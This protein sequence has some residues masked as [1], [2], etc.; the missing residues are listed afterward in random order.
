MAISL[1]VV[2]SVTPV[3]IRVAARYHLY[4]RPAGHKGHTKPTPYLGGAAVMAGFLLTALLLTADWHRTAPLV[5]GVLVM[6]AVGTID[7]KRTV[8]PQLRV[9]TEVALATLF[10]GLG[11]GWD[12]G[13]GAAV[14]WAATAVWVVAVVNA[15]NLFDNM[16][17]AASAM[18]TVV[19]AALAVLGLVQDDTW[20]AVVSIA[21]CG[22]CIG[23]LPHNLA[24]PSRIFLGDGG[25]MPMGFTV[26][27][28]AMVGTSSAAPEWQS[29]AM[30]LLLVGVPAL[31]T[32]LVIV[33]RKRR[34]V[35]V[36]AGGRDHITHR[37]HRRLRTARAVA[38]TLGA[39]QALVS[40][41]ALVAVRGNSTATVLVVVLYLTA[42]GLVIALL[43][44]KELAEPAAGPD[45]AEAAPARPGP[46][47]G[48]PLAVVFLVPLGIAVGLSP[49]FSGYYDATTWVPAALGLV[50]IVAAGAIARP[51]RVGPQAAL[52]LIGLAGL[53]L[54]A[55]ASSLWADSIEQAVVEGNR[56]L[57]YAVL[58]GAL[59][60]TVRDRRAAI[61]LLGTI[62]A[63]AVVVAG[64][65]LVRMLGDDA[66]SLFVA[67][68]LDA[69][70]GYINGQAS[71]Y[72]LT[73]WILIA[74]AERRRAALAGVALGA[75]TAVASLLVLSQSRG[76][77]VAAA[78]SVVLVLALVPG[79]TRRACAL[80]LLAAGVG[81]A[82]PTLVDVYASGP[83][84]I[85]TAAANGAASAALVAGAA[86]GLLWA[87]ATF[88][89]NRAG[90]LEPSLRRLAVA[91]VVAVGVAL[92]GAALVEQASIRTTL[93]E[94]YRAFV[95]LGIEPQGSAT[96]GARPTTRLASGAGTRYDYWRI[97]WQA[98][99]EHPVAGVGAGNY[100]KSY[101]ARRATTEDVRQPHSIEL[102]ALSELGLLGAAL[103]AALLGGI[104]WG[105]WRAAHAARESA[106]ARFVCVAGVGSVAAW[107][108]HTSVDWI[109]LLPG[110]TAIALA[111]A[112]TLLA[113]AWGRA[114]AAEPDAARA[115]GRPRVAPALAVGALIV[116][117][118][119]SL[120]RQGLADHF[121]S[122]AQDALAARPADALTEADRA[123]RL[124]A[125]SVEAYYVKAAALARFGRG[126]T[127]RATLLEAARREPRD[128]VTWTLLGDLAVRMGDLD[129]ARR[130]Y[131][132]ALDL[133]PRDPSLREL[134]RDPQAVRERSPG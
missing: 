72:L 23:F 27:V 126:A 123:L 54:L 18:G 125:E 13:F 66:A 2:Y 9:A 80:L 109:H 6:W 19:T 46:L 105:A 44:S 103:L 89:V 111:A 115:R 78:A 83:G 88:A 124:D 32:A 45:A 122:R 15:F 42:A 14:D 71:F 85:D 59:L 79:R 84:R 70:L 20:V 3:A 38:L 77:A 8:T 104:A 31:D 128:F 63:T 74:V 116:V 1:V 110:V 30:G 132:R 102:Q 73:L 99:R 86:V 96:P 91:G 106:T 112:V 37:A 68:R 41:L 113:P 134:A 117:A 58:V 64:W 57:A 75:A 76:I 97:A 108:V 47:P 119:V 39:A 107:L 12:L 50:T 133:N 16:D 90:R 4:D 26:A 51:P 95:R 24:S 22:A 10:W 67:G 98:W 120:S 127:A 11:L 52:V 61:W 7:D 53:G 60:I 118:S 93:G 100:D 69:P 36:L 62:A 43:D 49:F 40:A 81:L 129:D 33:S 114:P 92:G 56:L 29:L 55:L 131:R 28:L 121:R 21:L 48:V 130:L 35:S 5:A 34:G 65:T 101:F 87:L 82:A 25:S 94:Q 17:G